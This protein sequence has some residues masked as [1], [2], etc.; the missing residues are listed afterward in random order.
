MFAIHLYL[1]QGD[2]LLRKRK[3]MAETGFL[4]S[5][6]G[7]THITFDLDQLY[8]VNF[9][10]LPTEVAARYKTDH[11]AFRLTTQDM[12]SGLHAMLDSLS[13]PFGNFSALAV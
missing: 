1:R 2:R 3:N 7:R 10:F 5:E 4:S 13:E 6:I 12:Y 11:V 9:S 8:R